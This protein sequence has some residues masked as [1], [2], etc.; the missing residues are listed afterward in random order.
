MIYSIFLQI[1]SPGSSA[2]DTAQKA[3]VQIADPI[4]NVPKEDSIQLLELIFKGGPIMIPIGLLSIL[5]F[6]F[7]FERLITIN[8]AGKIDPNFINNIKDF[9]HVGNID[10]A[11]ALCK[12]ISNPQA[13]M[14]EKGIARIGKPLKEIEEAME[15]VGKQ[16]IYKLEKNITV[17]SIIG[18]IAPIIG[19][20]GTISG[21]IIIFYDI[22][23]SGDIS[24]KNIS[25]GLYQKMITSAGGLLVGLLAYIAYFIVNTKLDKSIHKME[26]GALEFMDLLHEPTK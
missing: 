8:K 16:E 7:F 4:S 21:V 11:K 12:N 10:A 5:T 3:M 1:T 25:N 17:L 9:I 18:R 19:F 26:S 24:I 20:I 14:I 22:G 15:N 23:L 13:R 2:L 6:Y